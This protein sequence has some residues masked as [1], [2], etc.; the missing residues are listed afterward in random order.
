MVLGTSKI[1]QHHGAVRAAHAVV[2]LQ[3]K[4]H[5]PLVEKGF[6]APPT[7]P[8]AVRLDENAAGGRR[9]LRLALDLVLSSF[10]LRLTLDL[11]LGSFMCLALDLGLGSFLRR[12][13]GKSN[14]RGLGFRVL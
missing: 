7:A 5:V 12:H 13:V 1:S 4:V 11:G 3:P 14:D 6:P 8:V 10:C 2:L 9:C